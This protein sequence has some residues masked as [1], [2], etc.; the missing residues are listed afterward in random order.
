[1]A[2]RLDGPA[3]SEQGKRASGKPP[4]PGWGKGGFFWVNL[5]FWVNLEG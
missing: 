5:V 4:S 1:M 2:L 3:S